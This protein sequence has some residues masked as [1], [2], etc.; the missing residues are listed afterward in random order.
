M[1]FCNYHPTQ[2]AR[3]FCPRC[4]S[5][6]CQGCISERSRGALGVINTQK[7][8]FC[9]KCNIEAKALRV[10]SFIRPFWQRLPMFFTYPLQPAPLLLILLVSAA[11]TL[12]SWIPL[13]GLVLWVVM[14]KYSYATLRNTMDGNLYPP[15]ISAEVIGKD[16]GEAFKQIA[17]F[18]IVI[19][20]VWFVFRDFGQ[21]LGFIYLLFVILLLPAMIIVLVISSSLVSAL[22]P[23][24]FVTVAFRIGWGYFLMYLFLVMLL[25]APA[26]LAKPLMSVMP[27]Q[28]WK[29]ILNMAQNY[30]TI[31][32]YNLMGYVLLQYHME[33]G[34]EV[35]AAVFKDQKP[36]MRDTLTP[37]A[38]N[39]EEKMDPHQDLLNQINILI[40]DG[41]A[42]DAIRLIRSRNRGPIQDPTLAER[43]YNLLKITQRTPEMLLHAIG[44][45][46]I[47]AAANDRN[48]TCEVYRECVAFDGRF[49]PSAET[50][51]RIADWSVQDGDPKSGANAFI[52]FINA[53]ADHTL[54]PKAHMLLARTLLEKLHQPAKAQQ[55]L[56]RL[57]RKYPD[58]DL[59]SHARKILEQ[60]P[61][62]ESNEA[63]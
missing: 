23:G 27:M 32:A 2:P 59:S 5:Y 30:Y 35:T 22:N 1:A 63:G 26:A 4:E 60:I 48:R 56:E 44:F 55:I 62:K 11:S 7:L 21:A 51:Y 25:A 37:P 14:I 34:Y 45:L 20:S 36:V 6:Y 13:L 16:L 54:A 15:T 61:N 53:N 47:L 52:K 18:V 46:D 12:L 28:L 3:Y 42:E 8:Y 33:L 49:T 41:R 39:A 19:V 43:Y 38:D 24:A 29:F 40:Q 17:L 50:L 57:I 10:G 9:P 31:V 58:H